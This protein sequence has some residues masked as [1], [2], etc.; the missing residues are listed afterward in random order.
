MS[1]TL[2]MLYFGKLP[3]RG[4]FVRSSAHPALIQSLDR[5]LSSGVELM[6]E[7]AHWK[8]I[9][10]QADAA[11]FAMI[12]PHRNTAVAGHL[13]PSTDLSGRRF[14]FVA[15]C[16]IESEKGA[17]LMA[18][19]PL[20]LQPAWDRLSEAAMK[21][22]GAGEADAPAL[23]A[24]FA[25]AQVPAPLAAPEARAQYQR[26]LSSTTL[27][28]LMQDLSGSG[29]ALDLRQILLALGLLLQP[30]M[31]SAGQ[32]IEKGLCLPLPRES[33]ARFAVAT[34]W[35]DVVSRFVGR[36]GHDLTLFLPRGI[37]HRPCLMIAF[38]AGAATALQGLLD[39]RATDGV[40]ISLNQSPWVE[41]YVANDYA[42]KKLS[43]YLLMPQMSLAQA[44]DSF[45]EAFLGS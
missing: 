19:G 42:L 41:D 5:W 10:D 30:V 29:A 27:A 25:H 6:A 23:L 4:D 21:A 16:A 37:N 1:T 18:L 20:M 17:D 11:H 45:Q 34:F 2:P 9:Y 26:F 38:S 14:P 40:F 13:V 31:N 32:P 39:T 33:F 22:R 7:D 43:S 24:D 12:S 15:G 36:S 44:L 8:P 3:G 35:M 28:M